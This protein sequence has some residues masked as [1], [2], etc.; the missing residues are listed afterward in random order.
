[1]VAV[2]FRNGKMKQ[3]VNFSPD[4]MRR[5]PFLERAA[6]DAQ[7]RCPEGHYLKPLFL[8]LLAPPTAIG[9]LIYFLKRMPLRI[10]SATDLE[11]ISVIAV[12]LEIEL[13]AE[14]LLKVAPKFAHTASE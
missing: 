2:T 8:T 10:S 6:N 12:A 1:M 3:T 9:N 5:C 4:E 14:E 7:Q 11:Q 13:L